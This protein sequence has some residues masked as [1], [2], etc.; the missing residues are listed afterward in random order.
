MNK[1]QKKYQY[2]FIAILCIFFY[3][4]NVIIG[5]EPVK[6]KKIIVVIDPGHGGKDSGAIGRK[7]K[8]KD[9]VLSISLK[10]GEYIKNNFPDVEII[11]TR[12]TDV[13]IPLHKRA[14][15]ANSNNADLFISIHA[16]SNKNPK[17][18]GTETFAMGLHKTKGNLEVA[19]K[20][21]SVIV[22]EEDYTTKYKGYDPNSSESYIIFS[23]MQNIYLDQSLNFASLVQEQ[24]RERT[25]RIDRGVKQA[26][27]LVLWNTTMPSV[28][29]EAGFISNSEEE[30]FLMSDIGQDYIAS[31][32]FRAF[33]EYKT[34]IDENEKAVNNMVENQSLIQ[35]N[36]TINKKEITKDSIIFKIQITSS[37]KPIPVDSSYFKGLE[38]VQE[39]KLNDVYKYTV[40]EE[41]DFKEIKKLQKSIRKLF[42]DAFIISFKN[43][44]KINVKE[45]IK[46]SAN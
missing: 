30:K 45:A 42:P 39:Q 17:P 13:F 14:E 33:K 6:G 12:T 20:E 11:Y 26:G 41:N 4:I 29:I 28:L 15:I 38:N 32:I 40:Y 34:L 7:A 23:L 10:L 3:T 46:I 18:Q 9:I 44:E 5:S 22:F 21:N 43:G 36:D 24:F 2:C 19:Q 25:K 27:F 1:L 31:A 35:N 37:S 8:E 16:N